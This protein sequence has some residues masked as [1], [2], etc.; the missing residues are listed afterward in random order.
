MLDSACNL[1]QL[2]HPL[3]KQ[4]EQK[5]IQMGCE[6]WITRIWEEFKWW[7]IPRAMEGT[8]AVT[9]MP[10][11]VCFREDAWLDQMWSE[12]DKPLMEKLRDFH[13]PQDIQKLRRMTGFPMEAFW[14]NI[15]NSCTEYERM[16]RPQF[17][18]V[19]GVLTSTKSQI[20]PI[21]I[22]LMFLQ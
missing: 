1:L 3:P 15:N 20:H 21:R 22:Q 14:K 2:S 19:K 8:N 9:S 5:S 17:A 18:L 10:E 13:T 12:K 16:E 11:A 7:L 4:E 6:S